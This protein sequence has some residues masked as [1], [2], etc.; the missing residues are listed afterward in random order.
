M[1]KFN[2]SLIPEFDCSSTGLSIVKWFQKA[3][4]VRKLFRIK[5]PSM[6]FPLR[7]R[8]GASAV[9]QQPEDDA[10]GCCEHLRDLMN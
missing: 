9:Y 4:W 10:V 6:V 1:D 8:K 7:L 2:L 3:E 5:E